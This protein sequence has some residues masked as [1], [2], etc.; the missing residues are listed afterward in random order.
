M[1]F[2]KVIKGRVVT[3]DRQIDN[4][5]IAVADG[6][7]AAIGDGKAPTA[8]VVHDFGAAWVLPGGIDAQ[9]HAGSYWG[10]DGLE[11]TSRGAICGGVTTMIEMPFD[12][13]EPIHNIERYREKMDAVE[14]LSYCDVALYGTLA[15]DQ[16]TAQLYE[17]AKAGACGFKISLCESHPVR[18]PRIS[19]N[20]QYELLKVAAELKLPVGIHNEDQEIVRASTT[21]MRE[22]GADGLSAHSESRPEAAELA[23][24]AL[25]LELAALTGAHGHIVHI[26]TSRGFDLVKR[27]RDAGN[28]ATG[29]ICMHYLV[30]DPDEDAAEFGAILKVNPP[31]RP[32]MKERL[33][34]R[35]RDGEVS[36]VS[37]DHS[38]MTKDSK[39]SGSIFQA[40]PGVPGIESLMPAF[41]TGLIRHDIDAPSTM[42]RVMS[43][44]PAKHFGI[45]PRKGALLQGS[46]ADVVIITPGHF[47]YYGADAHDG[48]NWSPYDG[49]E[50]LGKVSSTFLR[51]EQVWDG[52]TVTSSREYGNYIPRL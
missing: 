42:A 4:G 24:T 2:D 34:Q 35:V 20:Q 50:F 3:P 18:F 15:P 37:S 40:G 31:I 10:L 48:V 38:T 21:R 5:W 47:Q 49:K 12:H 9:T 45:W 13:P 29:E 19:A 8:E 28:E 22:S 11:A 44:N 52:Q 51:G 7:I 46:D 1:I 23:A 25:F 17:M 41:F 30:F 36:F 6:L 43:E 16:D 39:L 33:W 14:R 32:G 27:Y 26:S